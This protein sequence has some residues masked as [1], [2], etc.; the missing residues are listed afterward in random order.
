MYQVRVYLS[1]K[2]STTLRKYFAKIGYEYYTYKLLFLF[3]CITIYM[4]DMCMDMQCVY[5][6][7]LVG[8][9]DHH[10]FH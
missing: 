2:F 5:I 7:I 1:S 8:Y 10:V 4:D 9:Y 6:S 3:I